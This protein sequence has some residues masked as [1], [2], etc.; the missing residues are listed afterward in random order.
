MT[1]KVRR[2]CP[3][4]EAASQKPASRSLVPL[5][6]DPLD[7]LAKEIDGSFVV[8]VKLRGGKYRRRCFLTV[9]AAERAAHNALA[10]GYDAEV[11]LA[12][13]KPL[14]RLAGGTVAS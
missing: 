5:S 2:G 3:R 4:Q 7:D 6:S 9:A 10:A 13:L 14:W 12:Q 11:Y 1:P 8:V